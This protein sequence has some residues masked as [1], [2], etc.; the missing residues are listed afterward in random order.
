MKR[1]L[2]LLIL[3][4]ITLTACGKQAD[5]KAPEETVT[6]VT[7][8]AENSLED[9]KTDIKN[10]EDVAEEVP[11]ELFNVTYIEDN[12][13]SLGNYK[14]K[15][16]EHIIIPELIDW[17]EA[18]YQVVMIDED[19][20]ANHDE[21]KT[22][23][24]P[25]SVVEIK[26]N[27]FVNCSNIETIE[28]GEGIKKIG[29]YAF[30]V[31][32]KELNLPDGLEEIGYCA[33]SGLTNVTDLHIPSSISRIEDG[34]FMWCG[35]GA[36]VIPGNVKEIGEQAFYHC[37]NLK[38]VVLEEGVEIIEEKAFD[39]CEALESV[40]IPTSV[41]AIDKRAFF[42]S[43]NVTIYTPA[44]SYAESWAQENEI[45]CVIQ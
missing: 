38:S 28:F 11:V 34:A 14:G 25:N 23:V 27:A 17:K 9:E 45:P 36:L 32:L 6:K 33:F 5:T 42:D 8:Q 37:E 2:V 39:N 31:N 26:R 4:S 40:T 35:V 16:I 24:L 43:D 13:V 30:G 18:E 15:D 22:V 20:F 3:S 41:N 19:T 21:I 12:K 44:G 7:E 1:L 10:T 29:D